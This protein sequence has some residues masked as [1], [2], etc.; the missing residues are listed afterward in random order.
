M[1]ER[2]GPHTITDFESFPN[3]N[4]CTPAPGATVGRRFCPLANT[5]AAARAIR[6]QQTFDRY[7]AAAC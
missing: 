5:R 7:Q 3:S 4:L 6:A 2:P 1:K